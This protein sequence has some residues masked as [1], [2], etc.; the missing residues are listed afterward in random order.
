MH[1]ID[2]PTSG[3]REGERYNVLAADI[4]EPDFPA[5]LNQLLLDAP[6]ALVALYCRNGAEIAKVLEGFSRRN[7]TSYYLWTLDRGLVS[8]RDDGL[9]VPASRRINE[10]IRGIQLSVHF[11]MYLIP[12]ANLQFTPPLIAQLR[13]I[14]RA[15]DG[16]VKRIVLM[17]ESGD[18]PSSLSEYCAH[19]QLQPRSSAKLR[20]RDGRWI[21]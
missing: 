9:I 16:I 2:E 17:S 7:G 13:Q 20:L 19:V 10:A 5:R 8:L 4:T 18:L 1:L 14:A 11:A 12:A 21:R 3:W 6:C 15:Q